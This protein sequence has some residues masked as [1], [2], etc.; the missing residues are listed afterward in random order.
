MRE[1]KEVKKGK[2]KQRERE[3][4]LEISEKEKL[5][6]DFLELIKIQYIILIYK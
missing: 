2:E 5:N 4:E 3:R 1:K 6:Y